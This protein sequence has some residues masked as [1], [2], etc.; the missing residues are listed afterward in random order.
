[1]GLVDQINANTAGIV[2]GK[3][4]VER[5]LRDKGVQVTPDGTTLPTFDQLTTAIEGMSALGSITGAEEVATYATDDIKKGD[6]CSLKLA[7]GNF[8]GDVVRTEPTRIQKDTSTITLSTTF[9]SQAYQRGTYLICYGNDGNSY[10]FYWNGNTYVQLKVD[11]TYT[12]LPSGTS[13]GTDVDMYMFNNYFDDDKLYS[14]QPHNYN[15]QK[16][17]VYTIDKTNLNLVLKH[18]L[19]PTDLTTQIERYVNLYVHNNNIWIT[20]CYFSSGMETSYTKTP[21]TVHYYYDEVAGTITGVSRAIEGLSGTFYWSYLNAVFDMTYDTEDNVYL[22]IYSTSTNKGYIRKLIQSSS[23]IYTY[24]GGDITISDVRADNITLKKTPSSPYWNFTSTIRTPAL[25]MSFGCNTFMYID[26]SGKLRKFIVD[27]D[28]L[29]TEEVP[30]VFSDN[31]DIT[32]IENILL[33]KGTNLLFVQSNDSDLATTDQ[34]RIYSYTTNTGGVFT[35]VGTTTAF[36]N[37]AVNALTMPYTRPADYLSG[38]ETPFLSK[39][40]S[41][42]IYK[43]SQASLSFDYYSENCNNYLNGADAYGIAQYD[44]PIGETGNVIKILG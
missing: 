17:K 38:A 8:S 26:T 36:L 11:G 24:T 28:T 37:P 16:I 35:F 29:A 20:G 21:T 23:G 44:I 25:N 13:T 33:A 4:A 34:V 27:K 30:V 15:A 7:R 3:L 10:P 39:A 9:K 6:V 32:K 22:Y 40:G 19:E 2:A 5:A 41:L 1:M 12:N 18:T 31:L 42:V 14:L 43:I